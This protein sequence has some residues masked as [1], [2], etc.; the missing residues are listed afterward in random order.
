MLGKIRL[1][2]KTAC[3]EA[4]IDCL[5]F[6]DLRHT[7]GTRLGE[8]GVPLQTITKLF[9]HTTTRMTEKYVHTE[10]SVKEATEILASFSKR[11]TDISTDII[12]EG[13]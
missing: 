9:G 2:F 12:E 11:V 4:G 7:A 5:R 10:E 6:H 13:Q 3:V 8:S 1:S